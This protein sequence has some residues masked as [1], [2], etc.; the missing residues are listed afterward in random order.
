MAQKRGW[1][2]KHGRP[3]IL[4]GDDVGA[5]IGSRS[6]RPIETTTTERNDPGTRAAKPESR[7]RRPK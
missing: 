6:L 5:V 4:C 7:R 2:D 1:V 3:E